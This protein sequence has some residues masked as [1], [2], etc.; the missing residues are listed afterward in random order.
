MRTCP[1]CGFEL[2]EAL[3]GFE[4]IEIHGREIV[5]SEAVGQITVGEKSVTITHQQMVVFALLVR[6]KGKTVPTSTVIE[7]MEFAAHVQ[8]KRPA[9]ML[10]T[11]VCT[12]RPS[13]AVL[14]LDIIARRKYGRLLAWIHQR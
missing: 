3:P 7:E 14:G 6:A 5:F 9:E 11:T 12:V 10:N 2:V 8:Y 1:N 13:L 4:T